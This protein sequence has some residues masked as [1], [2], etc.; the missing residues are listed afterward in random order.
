MSLQDLE[1]QITQTFTQLRN[2]SLFFLAEN[3]IFVMGIISW[4]DKHYDVRNYA[5]FRWLKNK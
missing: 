4:F 3:A 5:R 2:L 1:M